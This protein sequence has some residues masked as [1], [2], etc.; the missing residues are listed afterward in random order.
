MAG[1]KLQAEKNDGNLSSDFN[2]KTEQMEIEKQPVELAI[3]VNAIV[4][5]C[6][7]FGCLKMSTFLDSMNNHGNYGFFR[8]VLLWH[9][10]IRCQSN[11]T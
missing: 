8:A 7:Y 11:A 10:V 9:C 5:L 3:Y 6:Y 2:E 4:C 1:R